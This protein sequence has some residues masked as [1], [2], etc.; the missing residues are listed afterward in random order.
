M[1]FL[2]IAIVE[3]VAGLVTTRSMKQGF[4]LGKVKKRSAFKSARV[5]RNDEDAPFVGRFLIEVTAAATGSTED[6]R[7]GV[8]DVEF[9]K[10]ETLSWLVSV[11]G[12]ECSVGGADC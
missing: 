2:F 1:I 3:G 4:P 8:L 9:G 6:L 11:E 5:S 10:T 7:A 12:S